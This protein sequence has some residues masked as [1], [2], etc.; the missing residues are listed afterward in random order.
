MLSQAEFALSQTTNQSNNF[1][2]VTF[3]DHKNNYP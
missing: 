3:L 1:H 2:P